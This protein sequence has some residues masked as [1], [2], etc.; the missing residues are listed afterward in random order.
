M[1]DG[2]IVRPLGIACNLKVI[3]F[4]KYI[5]TDFFI[6]DAYY[7][8]HVHVILKLV[9]S[10]LDVGKGKVTINLM[11]TSTHIVF[12]PLLGLLHPYLLRKKK[13]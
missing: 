4:E 8:K 12:F 11:V 5:P 3:I 10:V 2:R 13:R 7:D 6:I 9:N 1:G